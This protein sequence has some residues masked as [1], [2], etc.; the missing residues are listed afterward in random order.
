MRLGTL[1]DHLSSGSH[2]SSVQVEHT[3][4]VSHFHKLAVQ[5]DAAQDVIL[6]QA[7]LSAYWLAKE[8]VANRKFPSLLA[9]LEHAGNSTIKFFMHRSQQ[10]TIEIIQAIGD[11]LHDRTIGAITNCSAVGLLCDDAMDVS[12]VEQFIGFVQFYDSGQQNVEV[13]FLFAEDALEN[14][15]SANSQALYDIVIKQFESIGLRKLTG[16]CT[17]GAS[18]MVGKK[19]GLAAKLRRVCPDMIN[20]HCVCHKLALACA[21]ADQEL[22]YVDHM[23][24]IIRQLWQSMENSSKRTKAYMKTQMQ[25]HEFGL[26]KKM[27]KKVFKK[28]KKAYKTRWLSFNNSVSALYEDLPAVLLTLSSLPEKDVMACGLLKNI[29][30]GKFIATL[31]V[32]NSILPHLAYLSLAFQK[33]K[34][35][36]GHIKPALQCIKDAL[37]DLKTGQMLQTLRTDLTP[38]G[39]LSPIAHDVSIDEPTYKWAETFLGKYITALIVN[40]DE[41]FAKVPVVAAFSIFQLEELPNREESAFQNYGKDNIKQLAEHFRLDHDELLSEWQKIKYNYLQLRL[42]RTM[43]PK[44]RQET[45]E[46]VAQVE[47]EEE[48][49][50]ER[51]AEVEDEVEVEDVEEQRALRL[52]HLEEANKEDS[53]SDS[54]SHSDYDSDFFSDDDL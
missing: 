18:V 19:E 44:D 33:G 53:D 42:P 36:F 29:R 6:Q 14:S 12:V 2:K 43:M 8:E 25:L 7:F 24:T 46:G 34:V 17:D 26:N 11:E 45:G 38:E 35:N 32:L 20:L 1:G 54:D 3:Q 16:L 21:D 51:S 22:K 13:K 9:L 49:E 48:E 23:A 28:L 31:Y 4:R 30:S 5:K 27:K 10:S 47:E 15:D 41:R 40:L 50:V 39:R 52:F 37:K